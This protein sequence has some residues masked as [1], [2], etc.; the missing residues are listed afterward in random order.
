MWKKTTVTVNIKINLAS[1]L[2]GVAA[3]LT[4]LM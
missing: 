4:V 1:C 2:F 3:I